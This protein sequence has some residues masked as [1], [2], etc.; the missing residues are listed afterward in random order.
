M[1]EVGQKMM[2]TYT[3]GINSSTTMVGVVTKATKTTFE[4][5]FTYPNGQEKTTTYLQSN[6]RP[7]GKSNSYRADRVEVFRQ[8][9][10]D[11]RIAYETEERAKLQRIFKIHEIGNLLQQKDRALAATMKME[12]LE[13]FLGKVKAALA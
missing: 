3:G 9:E 7:W 5:Q 8:E 11:R 12:D 13:D 6:G 2:V 10:Y 1:V 4:V